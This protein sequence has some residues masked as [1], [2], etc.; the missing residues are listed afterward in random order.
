MN[1]GIFARHAG[2]R[3]DPFND[4]LAR[5]QAPN[6]ADAAVFPYVGRPLDQRREPHGQVDH[7]DAIRREVELLGA[8]TGK[9]MAGAQQVVCSLDAEL[10]H[11]LHRPIPWRGAH[12]AV[13]VANDLAR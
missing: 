5:L 7:R 11:A 1:V 2:G 8:L 3:F 13:V 9:V 4:A 6:E 10:L 12:G